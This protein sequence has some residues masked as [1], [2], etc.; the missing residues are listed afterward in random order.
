MNKDDWLTLTNDAVLSSQGLA[1]NSKV[2]AISSTLIIKPAANDINKRFPGI[3][4]IIY[5]NVRLQNTFGKL[6]FL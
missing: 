5:P 1:A 2:Q 4:I 6:A 3:I